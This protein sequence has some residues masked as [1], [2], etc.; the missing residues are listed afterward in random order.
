M[1]IAPPFPIRHPIREV[2]TSNRVVNEIRPESLSTLSLHLGCK[3]NAAS[4]AGENASS[5]AYKLHKGKKVI[6]HES[7][8]KYSNK[9]QTL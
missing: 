2:G 6:L 3:R 9:D 8:N 7:E 1:I 4:I 5:N